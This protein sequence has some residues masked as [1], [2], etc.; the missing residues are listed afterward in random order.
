MPTVLA[1]YNGVASSE[2][3]SVLAL[4]HR[5]K[6]ACIASLHEHCKGSTGH[7]MGNGGADAPFPAVAPRRT[8]L[9]FEDMWQLPPQDKVGGLSQR[10]ERAWHKELQKAKPSL[11]RPVAF[12][13]G[14]AAW[15]ACR[16]RS[17]PSQKRMLLAACMHTWGAT[18]PHKCSVVTALAACIFRDSSHS[19]M[20]WLLAACRGCNGPSQMQGSRNC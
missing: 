1:C 12:A 9:Q 5:Q 20:S 10:F 15:L 7:K 4:V 8:P 16:R 18:S 19:A 14:R 2:S 6:V 17:G 13:H 11:V 3:S